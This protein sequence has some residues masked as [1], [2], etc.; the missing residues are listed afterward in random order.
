MENQL[1]ASEM[2]LCLVTL[3][4]YNDLPGHIVLSPNPRM[5]L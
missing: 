4:M 2:G 5:R 3:D 1:C